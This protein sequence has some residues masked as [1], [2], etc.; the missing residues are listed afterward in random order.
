MQQ[1]R[2]STD[3]RVIV[4]NVN[5]RCFKIKIRLNRLKISATNDEPVKMPYFKDIP[6]I[7]S[8]IDVCSIIPNSFAIDVERVEGHL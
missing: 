2:Y 7:I 8:Q 5:S 1:H 6:S 4:Q 3:K